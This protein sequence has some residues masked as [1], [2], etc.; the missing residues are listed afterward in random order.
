MA[1]FAELGSNGEVISVHVVDNVNLLDDDGNEQEQAGIDY[2]TQVHGYTSWVQTSY[3][4]DTRKN[5]A[6]IGF[7]YDDK[8]DA[9]IRPKPYTSWTLNESTCLW[10]APVSRPTDNKEYNWNEQ[11]QTWDVV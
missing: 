11:T 7:T 6:G 5:Y 9:F 8:R 1:H 4:N 10:E 2:L 3:N